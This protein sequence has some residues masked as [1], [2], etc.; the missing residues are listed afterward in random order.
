MTIQIKES[1]GQKISFPV[2]GF[3]NLTG[4]T[5]RVIF[6][7]EDGTGFERTTTDGDVEV[8]DAANNIIT[9]KIKD[10]DFTVE[11][12]YKYQVWD[13][14]NG[15]RIKSSVASFTVDQTLVRPT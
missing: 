5:L 4:K 11:G 9:V 2:N 10:G 15:N 7:R 8:V 1:F 6:T 3:G 12:T 13:E 14:T